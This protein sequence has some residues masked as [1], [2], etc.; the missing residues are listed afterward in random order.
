MLLNMTYK[1]LFIRELR[2]I[3]LSIRNLKL[4]TISKQKCTVRD[5]HVCFLRVNNV[6]I[7]FSLPLL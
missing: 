7:R 3:S 6:V 4:K 2:P 5:I 1:K